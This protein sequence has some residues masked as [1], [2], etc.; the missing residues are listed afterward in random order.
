MLEA[1]RCKIF[2]LRRDSIG[3]LKLPDDL[4]QGQF[5]QLTDEEVKS[6]EKVA[7]SLGLNVIRFWEKEMK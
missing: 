1:V 7:D 4:E 3:S 2:Y 5:R 6:L